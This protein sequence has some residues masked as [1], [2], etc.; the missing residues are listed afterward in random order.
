MEWTNISEKKLKKKEDVINNINK[1]NIEKN[2]KQ[3]T[4]VSG[5][6]EKVKKDVKKNIQP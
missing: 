5:E 2:T 1:K 4:K 3:I 6:L